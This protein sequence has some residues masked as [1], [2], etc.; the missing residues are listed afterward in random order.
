MK[1]FKRLGILVGLLVI[2]CVAAF[3]L[4][5]YEEKKEQIRNSDEIV[6]E[7]PADSVQSL[8]WEYE[9]GGLSF[10]KDGIWY[11]D[12]DEAFPV[13][14]DKVARI[15]SHFEAFGVTFVIEDVE[16][17][18]QY[19]L[20]DPKCVIHLATEEQS[21][22]IKLG[23]F[24][25]MDEQRYVDIGDGNVYLVGSDPMDYVDAA[26]SSMICHDDIP[27][28]ET[29]VDITFSGSENYTISRIDDS[30]DSYSQED[31]Y[32]TAHNGEN[33]PLDTDRV[34][35]Y[36]STAAAVDLMDYVTYNATE[37]ELKSYGL[38]SPELS[39]TINYTY[40]DENEEEVSDT[41][42]FHI[43]ENPEERK[44]AEEAE[45]GEET[46]VTKYIR[47]GD[48][49]IVYQLDDADYRVLAA[50][51]YN[52]LRHKE[53]IWADF[54]DVYQLDITLEDTQH[55]LTS[56]L[57]DGVRSWYLLDE[58]AQ[59]AQEETGTAAEETDE[60]QEE[61]DETQEDADNTL[62]I[63]DLQSALEAL[64][65]NS[66]T[67]E[68]PTGKEEISLTVYLDNENHP[69][70]RIRLYRYDGTCCLAVVD[71]ESVSLVARSAVMD[72]V[73]AVQAIVLNQ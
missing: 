3:A 5:R 23:D 59:T 38:D 43:S 49:Q 46:K 67:D 39:V 51:S 44:A 4:T 70:V 6:L 64:T 11:Y 35:N 31:I 18:G 60:T 17:Y 9:D 40:T 63:D 25:K 45:D 65:A 71:G 27:R 26:L 73:E 8:S 72:L 62:D 42:I 16:D 61:T 48:S 19:G 56:T 28:L 21:Y 68:A 2:V 15:L 14:Q 12:E 7:I 36:L 57:E 55:T 1:R 37:N 32:F 30:T 29:V 33:R 22:D 58:E 54:N 20:E 34:K 69:Q 50:A 13:D 24:S 41:C 47:I 53:V 66:F 10:H 52:D